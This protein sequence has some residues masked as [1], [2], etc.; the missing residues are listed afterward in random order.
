MLK[1]WL[2][3][4]LGL[5][6]ESEAKKDATALVVEEVREL[7]RQM[8]RLSQT[9]EEKFAQVQKPATKQSEEM[10]GIAGDIKSIKGLLLSS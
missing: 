3:T 5:G 6:H 2:K 8:N 7:R 1:K 4:W 9:V 10:A